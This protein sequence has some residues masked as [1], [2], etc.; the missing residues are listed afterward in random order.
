MA[1][2]PPPGSYPRSL[3]ALLLLLAAIFFVAESYVVHFELR[4]HA[5]SFTL[6]EIPVVLGLFLCSPATL[7][8]AQLVGA[9]LGLVRRRQP[10]VKLQFNIAN[11]WLSTTLAIAVMHALGGPHPDLSGTSL[12]ATFAAT[13]TASLVGMT[14]IMVAI[15]LSGGENARFWNESLPI[16][17]AITL[18][19]TGLGII[20][21]AVVSFRP[22]IAWV[23]LVPCLALFL[24]Y[25]AYTAQREKNQSLQ[26][27]YESSRM[28]HRTMDSEQAIAEILGKARTMF[29]ADIAEMTLFASKPED[30]HVRATLGPQ[31][32]LRITRMQELE[33][34]D[35][36]ASRVA[37]DDAS[38]LISPA[39]GDKGLGDKLR[40]ANLRDAMATSL[41]GN[42][43]V[44]GSL[45]VANRLSDVST[46]RSKDVKLLETM[47]NNVSAA[48]ENIRL[49]DRLRSEAAERRYQALHDSLTGLPNRALFHEHLNQNIHNARQTGRCVAVLLIDLDGFRE[50]NDT[51]GHHN[52]DWLLQKVATRLQDT[53]HPDD[54][55]ARLGGDEFAV[56][57]PSLDGPEDAMRIAHDMLTRLEQVLIV[58]GIAVEVRASIGIA[59]SPTHG[60]DSNLLMQRADVA[61]YVAKDGHSGYEMYAVEK[62]R[63]SERRLSLAAELRHAIDAG[64]IAVYYQPKARLSDGSICGAEALARWNHSQRGPVRPDEFIPIA[65]QTGLVKPLTLYV[66][67]R[68]LRQVAEWKD[69]GLDI[70]VAVNL[71]ARSLLDLE[72]PDQVL[73]L[74][75]RWSVAPDRLV[76]EITESF[77][78]SDPLRAKA[79]VDRL[80]EI[81]VVLAI[82]DFGTGY[83]SLAYLKR[84]P[85]KELKVDRS[86]ISEMLTDENDAV[87]VRSTIELGHNLGLSVVAEGVESFDQWTE[88]ASLGCDIAQG[89]FLS[90]AIPADELKAWVQTRISADAALSSLF[91]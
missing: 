1:A 49:A 37:L 16:G 25:R 73:Q 39:T 56:C 28:L 24:A 6:G 72:L 7:L 57:L 4:Q 2:R 9:G 83:S 62:D 47:A 46:F 65:E 68:V 5:H 22:G 70:S 35:W 17:L 55:V 27:L 13:I 81:G 53:L 15:W 82:D 60:Q 54:V 34:C 26:S 61:M 3:R 75:E 32:G 58:D 19:N 18:S 8:A 50:V 31:E 77:I 67:D 51:L 20:A 52:G 69:K 29:K 79:V 71:S 89:Y 21:V 74:L 88:L 23:L 38:H 48:L 59:T 44:I 12:P 85:I 33:A 84:L 45:M 43:G 40:G 41:H 42:A 30:V 80:S 86:F 36:L 11:V 64:E 14:G 87:I 10:G 91:V 63:Y 90:P 66:I 78:M 76:L